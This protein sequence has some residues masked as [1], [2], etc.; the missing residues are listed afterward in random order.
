MQTKKQILEW[1]PFLAIPLIKEFEGLSLK[2]YKCPA[3][4]WTIGYGHTKEVTPGLVVSKE[5]AEEFL[6]EDL[7]DKQN[8]MAQMIQVPVTKGQFI[9][10]LSFY[11]NE[12]PRN[13]AGFSLRM[14]RGLIVCRTFLFLNVFLYDLCRGSI[15]NRNHAVTSR[16]KPLSP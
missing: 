3:G 9:A 15:A 14:D 2:A 4:I 6:L 5:Q 16:P 8:T 13:S 11:F 1:D 7:K 12:R 10:L